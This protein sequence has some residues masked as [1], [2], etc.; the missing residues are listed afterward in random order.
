MLATKRVDAGGAVRFG[1]SAPRRNQLAGSA[2][3]YQLS[4]RFHLAK[5]P[6]G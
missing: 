4:G 1:A 3:F 2:A 5:D 6:K